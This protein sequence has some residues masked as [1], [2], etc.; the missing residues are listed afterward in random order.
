MA[1]IPSTSDSTFEADVLRSELPVVVDF[2][3]TWCH[4]C[5]QLEPIL[6]ELA[7]EWQGRV[8]VFKLDIDQNVGTTMKFGVMGVPTLILFVAGEA[9]GRVSGF[10]PK[11]KII[12]KLAPSL[13]QG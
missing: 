7:E 8:R 11:H 4:P 12:E 13:P 9:K 6:E 2:G 5:V 3:A 10:Q 1:P